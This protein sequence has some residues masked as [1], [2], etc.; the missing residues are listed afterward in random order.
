M[1]DGNSKTTGSGSAVI[2]SEQAQT[3]L[4]NLEKIEERISRVYALAASLIAR[5]E[6]ENSRTPRESVEYLL[7]EMIQE[8]AEENWPEREIRALLEGVSV[9]SEVAHA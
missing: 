3:A 4:F 5:L 8:L 9:E 6:H 2:T 1:A 7:A